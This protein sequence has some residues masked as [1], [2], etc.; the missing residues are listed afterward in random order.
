MID[1]LQPCVSFNNIN[2]Y[3]WYQNRVYKLEKP[4]STRIEAMKIAEQWGKKIPIGVIYQNNEPTYE[5]RI[6][7]L[8][9]SALIKSKIKGNIKELFNDLK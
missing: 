9:K 7:A 8:K 3:K 5:E 6:P 1:I 2:T 4:A